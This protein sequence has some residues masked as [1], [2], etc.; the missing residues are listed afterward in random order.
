M[1]DP[2]SAPPL[3]SPPVRVTGGSH[4]VAAT[5]AQVR[6]L[7]TSYDTAGNRLRDRAGLGERTLTD[8]DLLESALLSPGS[9]ADAEGAVLATTIGPDGLLAGSVGWEVDA[10]LVRG[11]VAAFEETDRLMEATFEAV[12]TTLGQLAGGVASGLLVTG[13][14]TA[15]LWLP[16]LLLQ[17]GVL[18]GLHDLLPPDLR[19][20]LDAAGGALGDELLGDLQQWV[21]SHPELV[22]HAFNGA[23]GFLQGFLLGLVPGRPP[24]VPPFAP[25][26]ED[27][28]GILAGLYPPDGTPVVQTRD[29]LA[30]PG[31]RA[32]LPGSLADVLA[33]LDDVNAWSPGPDSA[34]NGTIEIQT[35][36]DADGVPHHVVYI[37]GTDDLTTLPW[38]RDG[39]VR[40]LPTNLAVIGGGTT[41]Y[42]AG[43]LRA[44]HDAGIGPD[45][46]VMM[47]GHSQGGMEAVWAA[48][49]G[50]FTVT[51]VVT[52]G[53]PVGALGEPPA[54]TQVLSLENRGDV[55]PLL[56]G[57]ANADTASHVTV[58][59]S[60]GGEGI[61]GHHDLGHYV[62]G[63]AGVDASVDPSLT[64]HLATLHEEGFLTGGEAEVTFQAFQITRG[65]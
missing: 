14:L 25:T 22:Q 44:M 35:W 50:E 3:P 41:T 46:P 18:A 43:I 34:D 37:P 36:V 1:S 55:V 20:R 33:H 40:D 13:T 2:V 27:A 62:A 57:E 53:A 19:R 63:A 28:A 26:T 58:T 7:A 60:D 11:S 5:Y 23:G 24:G 31:G 12:D 51:Q 30:T 15:P 21:V 61:G 64:D 48:T 39:D 6:A 29:D 45:D 8:A 56:D 38:T 32:P 42:G 17:G 59:F 47:V 52:A 54:G 9:F 16:G 65:P 4:G 49:T 10:L